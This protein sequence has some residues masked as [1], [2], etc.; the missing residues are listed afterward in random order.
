MLAGQLH[1]IGCQALMFW[2]PSKAL[3]RFGP[4]HGHDV[5]IAFAAGGLLLVLLEL[6][7]YPFMRKRLPAAHNP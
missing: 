6:A 2:P 7:K 1:R 5:A 3:F 4:L